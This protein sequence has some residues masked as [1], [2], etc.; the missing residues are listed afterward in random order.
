MQSRYSNNPFSQTMNQVDT[1]LIQVAQQ[2]CAVHQQVQSSQYTNF[3]QGP[4][5]SDYSQSE[6]DQSNLKY[7]SQLVL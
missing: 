1:A 2:I 3:F 6:F 7:A 5:Q 4:A